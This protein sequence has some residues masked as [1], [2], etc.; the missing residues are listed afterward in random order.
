M[1]LPVSRPTASHFAPRIFLS[2]EHQALS[3]LADEVGQTQAEHVAA[4]ARRQQLSNE[5]LAGD[6][7]RVN[8]VSEVVAEAET[9]TATYAAAVERFN[10][11]GRATVARRSR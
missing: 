8:L 4:N 5:L 7:R 6:Y 9:A 11:A 3:A 1:T 2:P 10:E